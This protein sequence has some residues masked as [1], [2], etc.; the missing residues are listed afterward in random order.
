MEHQILRMTRPPRRGGNGLWG[1][2]K[3]KCCRKLSRADRVTAVTSI[4]FGT[5]L[6]SQTFAKI[7][8]SP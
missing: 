4:L 5:G 2:R 7:H 1:A 6:Q 8:D 3:G